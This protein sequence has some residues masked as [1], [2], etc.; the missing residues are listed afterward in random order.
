MIFIR[1][2]ETDSMSDSHQYGKKKKTTT[3]VC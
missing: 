3:K 1:R 2:G